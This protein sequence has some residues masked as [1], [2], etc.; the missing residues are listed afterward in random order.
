MMF[1]L[2]AEN[3]IFERDFCA[4]IFVAQ[5]YT[6]MF[7]QIFG[8]HSSTHTIAHSAQSEEFFTNFFF[9]QWKSA[10][11]IHSKSSTTR[12]IQLLCCT[13]LCWTLNT[14]IQNTSLASTLDCIDTHDET[15]SLNFSLESFRSL[16]LLLLPLSVWMCFAPAP[17]LLIIKTTT[18]T[19]RSGKT[20][21]ID[22]KFPQFSISH[23]LVHYLSLFANRGLHVSIEFGCGC[24]YDCSCG[25]V[26][27]LK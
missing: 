23:T 13:K 14:I 12:K 22:R 16:L 2:S 5:T 18:T 20:L 19:R 10:T 25:C 9:R 6:H 24:G 26:C 11:H 1:S 15:C 21:A 27:A 3:A 17:C 8:C 7:W 4:E